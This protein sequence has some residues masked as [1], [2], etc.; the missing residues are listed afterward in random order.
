MSKPSRINILSASALALSA[1]L[2]FGGVACAQEQAEEADAVLD[3]VVVTGYASANRDAIAAKRDTDIIIDAVSQDDI[4]LLPD[5]TISQ[6][7][8]RIP[9]VTTLSDNGVSG[10][11]SVNAENNVVIRGL[12]PDFNLTTFDGVPI[13]STSEDDRAANLSII[14]PTIVSRVEA[15]KTLTSDMNPH[16]LS[17]Q[18]NLVTSSA[19]DRGEPFVATRF[20]IGQN[21]LTGDGPTADDKPDIRAR[22]V[23]ST[24][25][26][27]NDQFGFSVSGSYDERYSTTFDS[28]PGAASDTYLFYE[29]V[30][31]ENPEDP[32]GDTVDFF[33]ESN[34]YAA[35]RRNQLYLFENSAERASGV[36][37][38]EYQPAGGETYASLFGGI[39]Y[40]NEEEVRYEHLE[41]A[42]E[43]FRPLDQTALTGTWPEAQIQKGY[44]FQPEESTTYVLTGRYERDF[45]EDHELELIASASRAEVDVIRNMSKFNPSDSE[46]ASFYY[47]LTNGAPEVTYLTPEL[48]ND[49]SS[50]TVNYIRERGQTIEHDLFYLSAAY[51]YNFERSDRGF[52]ARIGA[53]LTSRE[54]SFDRE[55]IQG[56]VFDTDGCTE[57]DITDCDRVRF[58]DYVLDY[59]RAGY[60]PRII[61][62]FLDDAKLRADWAAQGKPLTTDRTDD[63]LSSDYHLDE[64]IFALF[65]QVSYRTDRFSLLAG[66]R[67]DDTQ[68]DVD[69]WAKDA[70]LDDD[71]DDAAQFVEVSRSNDYDFLLPSVIASYELTDNLILRGGYGR[72]IGRPDFGQ[73]AGS[74]SIGEPDLEFGTI[75]VT[76]GN[77]DLKPLVADNYDLSLEYYFDDGNGMISAAGFYKDV[78]DLIYTQTTTGPFELDGVTYDATFKQPINTT[79]ASIYGLELALRSELDAY[80]PA[81]LEGFGIEA[82]ATWIGSDFTFINSDGDARDPG[83]WEDQPEFLG[84]FQGSYERGR[85][86]A[87]LGYSYVGSF[88]SDIL[89]DEGDLYDLYREPRGTWDAQ[90][91][92]NVSD[93]LRLIAE[94]K[95]IAEEGKEYTRTFPGLGELEGARVENGRTIWLGFS[96]TPDIAN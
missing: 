92:Y 83:G 37:K 44:V 21:S 61:F 9:G 93:S 47:D 62:Y 54:Q 94:V 23:F 14:P 8:A 3:T 31:P 95:N 38:L 7:A 85:F 16:G 6:V 73:L 63:S 42:N 17:G 50:D 84:K 35:A 64:Q 34:G 56:R 29:P 88:L 86:G 52:G 28:R 24:P 13:A 30:D 70:A 19:F 51:G 67:Y 79:D 66:L 33:D 1:G 65:G 69:V 39:F 45:G 2:G 43:D 41:V 81:S 74:E 25:F 71:P 18:I 77:P 11:R 68:A 22:A 49:I 91:R 76:R 90:V 46:D 5:V 53:Q 36:I 87:K 82:S 57:E 15:R 20:S 4:G 55:Y 78:S 96:W 12:D 89:A 72:T 75:S 59:T 32:E 80:L 60:D 58:D 26:G 48:A 40:Q 27:A 10:V